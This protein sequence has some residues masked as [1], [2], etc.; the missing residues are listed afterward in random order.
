MEASDS[1]DY[2][3]NRNA[4]VPLVLL[5]GIGSVVFSFAISNYMN[6]CFVPVAAPVSSQFQIVTPDTFD[7]HPITRSFGD[8]R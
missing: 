6:R 2:Q 8:R 5:L 7:I 1:Q 3:A 4:L